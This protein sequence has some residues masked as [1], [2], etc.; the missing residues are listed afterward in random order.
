MVVDHQL[1]DDDIFVFG[2]SK[3]RRDQSFRLKSICLLA[4]C[5]VVHLLVHIIE[6]AFLLLLAVLVFIEIVHLIVIDSLLETGHHFL[7]ERFLLADSRLVTVHC[8][9]PGCGLDR[10]IVLND[11]RVLVRSQV[12]AVME[13]L[14]NRW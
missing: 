4:H 6:K 10:I 5:I 9:L 12:T 13:S 8:C 11:T 1:F 7:I 2:R 3:A 14:N